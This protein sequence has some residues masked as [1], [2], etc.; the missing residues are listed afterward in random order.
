MKRIFTL[1]ELLVVIAIIAILAAMLLP[2]LNKAKEKGRSIQCTGNMKQ[3]GVAFASYQ[4]NFN[5]YFPPSNDKPYGGDWAT[6]IWA[7]NFR[8]LGLLKNSKVYFCP[9]IYSHYTADQRKN[10]A[11]LKPDVYNAY[12]TVTYSGI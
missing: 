6:N 5:D 2:T 11:Y 12:V 1:I 4:G 9:T 3:I 7:W 10:S 8:E